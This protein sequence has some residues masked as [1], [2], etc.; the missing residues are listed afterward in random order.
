MLIQAA[1]EDDWISC[2]V[3]HGGVFTGF[4]LVSCI[5]RP[6]AAAREHRTMVEMAQ[7]M[8]VTSAV[9]VCLWPDTFSVC[10]LFLGSVFSE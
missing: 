9:Y 8:G 6:L 1:V 5:W 4:V 10:L 7:T 2:Q 3:V